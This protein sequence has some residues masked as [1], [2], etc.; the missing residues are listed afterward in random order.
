MQNSLFAL[1]L[2]FCCFPVGAQQA[3]EE[4]QLGSWY[5]YFFNKSFKE[6]RFGLQGDLQY[7][8][9]NAGGDLEQLLLRSGLTYRPENT[10]VMLTLGYADITS[11]AFGN[12]NS[13]TGERRLYQEALLPQKIIDRILLTHRFRYEQRFV[14]GQD[15]RT[16]Y[17]YNI[18]ANVL[19]N[20][21]VLEKQTLYLAL[22]NEIFINGQTGI[23]DGRNVQRFDRNRTYIGLGYGLKDNLRIQVGWMRQTTVNWGKNQAQFSLHHAW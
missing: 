8:G 2:I 15:F 1:L 16:R 5:M 22:Y 14:D 3:V 13:T 21:A 10:S 11:G 9:W 7:R 18:F 17:R 12:N 4:E 20:K 6:G 23:G 19:L